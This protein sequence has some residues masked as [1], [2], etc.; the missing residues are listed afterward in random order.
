MYDF[1]LDEQRHKSLCDQLI[2]NGKG[3]EHQYDFL[4][5][6]LTQH[7][8]V[9]M[10]EEKIGPGDIDVVEVYHEKLQESN[11]Q[12]MTLDTEK[13]IYDLWKSRITP[14]LAYSVSFWSRVTY[15]HIKQGKIE[16][17]FLAKDTRGQIKS[18]KVKIE[19][20]L[21]GR[22]SDDGGKIADEATR[23]ALRN[24]GGLQERGSRSAIIDCALA[25]VWWRGYFLKEISGLLR[26]TD[27]DEVGELLRARW[28]DIFEPA[29]GK[30]ATL[31]YATARSAL[32]S[33]LLDLSNSNAE[34][35]TSGMVKSYRRKLDSIG[36]VQELGILSIE[37][38]CDLIRNS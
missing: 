34:K 9:E 2:N 22:N 36:C 31:G 1:Y 7:G 25:R 10:Y 23:N 8:F 18:G 30:N 28:V 27:T 21:D 17:W 11:F 24:L 14:A 16:P 13:K 5:T 37:D 33:I 29:V 3:S 15:M 26:L 4:N 20:A 35:V 19:I 12:Q 6:L 38:I 32:V